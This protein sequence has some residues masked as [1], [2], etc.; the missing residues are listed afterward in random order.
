MKIASVAFSFAE[1]EQSVDPQIVFNEISKK[2]NE[3]LA[4]TGVSVT[5]NQ[6]KADS[7]GVICSLHVSVSEPRSL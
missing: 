5:A 4:G 3:Q 1:I 7:D 2:F 6:I